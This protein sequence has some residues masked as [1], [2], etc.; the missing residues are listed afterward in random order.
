MPTVAAL[1]VVLTPRTTNRANTMV[2]AA[3]FSQVRI[4]T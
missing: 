4:T 1:A 2:A 3:R